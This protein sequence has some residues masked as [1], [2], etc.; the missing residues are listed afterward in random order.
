VHLAAQNNSEDAS[1][2]GLMLRVARREPEAQRQLAERLVGRVRR[3]SFTLL[4]DAVEADDAAQQS[5]VE[6]LQSAHN[7]TAPGK[8][9]AWADTI[10]VR[11]ALRMARRLRAHRSLFEHLVNPEAL[12]SVVSDW[13]RCEITPRQLQAYLARIPARKREAFVLKHA[14]GYT[15]DE[16]ATLTQSPRGTVKD[17]LVVARKQLRRMIARDFR[18]GTSEWRSGR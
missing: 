7:F 17:R 9:E 16:I 15:V 12:K 13:G 14:L 6:I 18:L 11:T 5:L 2:V 3:L 4:Q 1:D 10:T 8:L